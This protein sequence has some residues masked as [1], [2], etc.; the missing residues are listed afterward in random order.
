[1]AKNY[2]LS[3]EENFQGLQRVLVDYLNIQP[4]LIDGNFH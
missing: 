1:M 3:Q 2:A 4:K